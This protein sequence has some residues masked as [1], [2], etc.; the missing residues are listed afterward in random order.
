[1]KNQTIKNTP[2]NRGDNKEKE[3]EMSLRSI[4][5]TYTSLPEPILVSTARNEIFGGSGRGRPA[6]LLRSGFIICF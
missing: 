6:E 5:L 1:M 2:A 3:T 4:W